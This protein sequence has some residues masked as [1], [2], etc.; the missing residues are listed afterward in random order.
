[1]TLAWNAVSG[2]TSYEVAVRD[3]GTG[4][5]VVDQVV[6]GTSDLVS[7]TAGDQYRW[8]VDAINSA[9]ASSFTT[10]L[11][12]QLS[13]PVSTPSNIPVPP[14]GATA[15]GLDGLSANKLTPAQII[16]DKKAFVI[17]YIGN[18]DPTLGKYFSDTEANDLKYYGI[19][20]VSVFERHILYDNNGI[21]TDP[22]PND[23]SYFM[24][25][26]AQADSDARAAILGAT[27]AG[28]TGGSRIP[29]F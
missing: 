25:P 24:L 29:S 8:N 12:F 19:N 6:S 26:Q 18:P 28:Q 15:Y 14:I 5:L 1:M 17:R 3:I 16:A 21:A 9:G 20:I 4:A 23:I 7:L 10:P 22:A 13:S 11:Y 27:T 2:A